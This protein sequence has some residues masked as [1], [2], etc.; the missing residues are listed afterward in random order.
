MLEKDDQALMFF[1]NGYLYFVGVDGGLPIVNTRAQE[2][3]LPQ[4]DEVTS[5]RIEELKT[6]SCAVEEKLRHAEEKKK[7]PQKKRQKGEQQGKLKRAASS[8]PMPEQE[9][10]FSQA[11]HGLS[12]PLLP[13]GRQA[14]RHPS[15]HQEQVRQSY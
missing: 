1:V 15:L 2:R 13:A 4:M 8:F 9:Y 5:A 11:G 12:Q 6:K 10:N 14:S 3:S 7:K